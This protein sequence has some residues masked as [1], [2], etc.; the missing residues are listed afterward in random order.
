MNNRSN[1]W[2]VLATAVLLFVLVAC[3]TREAADPAVQAVA[4]RVSQKHYLTYRLD[5]E[6]MG[7][8]LYGGAGYDMGYRSHDGSGRAPVRSAIR[9]PVCT[10]RTCSRPWD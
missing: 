8:G 3:C 5:V 6:N 1:A 7:L 4:D 10:S 9:K 2:I